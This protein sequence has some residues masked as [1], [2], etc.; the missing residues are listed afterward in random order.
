M[1][2]KNI[3][4]IAALCVVPLSHAASPSSVAAKQGI[5]PSTVNSNGGFNFQNR[6]S[7]KHVGWCKG[8]G[9]LEDPGKSAT[10]HRN[11]WEC[12][13]EEEVDY[14]TANPDDPNCLVL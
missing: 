7:G 9:H 13:P 1:Q 6:D 4:A 3:L 5:K 14:C 8:V 10:G 12:E 2:I 11:H